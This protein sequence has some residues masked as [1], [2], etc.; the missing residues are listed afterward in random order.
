MKLTENTPKKKCFGTKAETLEMLQG[1]LAYSVILPLVRFTA[2]EWQKNPS[3]CLQ[4]IQSLQLHPTATVIIRSSALDEDSENSSAAGM[5]CSRLN[6]PV[7]DVKKLSRAIEEVIESFGADGDIAGHQVFAQP[8]LTD[9]LISGVVFTR[10][11]VTLAPYYVINYDDHSRLTDTVTSGKSND[12]KTLILYKNAEIRDERLKPLLRAIKEVEQILDCDCL[13]IE[14]SIDS[15]G[16]VYVFQARPI[17]TN[18]RSLPDASAIG[19]YLEKIHKKI[20]KLNRPHPYVHGERTFLGVMPD[21]NPAEMLGI[22]PRPLA[23]SLYKE[24]ITDKTW[25]HQRDNYG[26]K[27]L[28]SYPLLITLIGH[29]YVDVRVSFNSF[30]PKNLD[31]DLSAKLCNFYLAELERTPSSHDKIEFDII[32]SCFF[33]NLDDKLASLLTKGFTQDEARAIRESLRHLTNQII[34]PKYNC[35]E[36]DFAKINELVKRQSRVMGSELTR[37]EKIFWL[38]EDCRR[39]GTLPFAGLARGGFIAIQMLNSMVERGW[40]SPFEKE[41]FMA[42]LNTVTKQMARDE[43]QISKNDFLAKYGHLRPG[44]YD[45]LSKRYDEAFE[46]Y[47]GNSQRTNA[48]ICIEF[49]FQDSFIEKLNSFILNEGFECSAYELLHFIKSAIEGREHAKFVFTKS[50]SEILRLIG[51]LGERYSLNKEEVSFIDIRTLLGLYSTLDHRD[52]NTILKEEIIRNQHH[53]E[54][55]K[56]VRLPQLILKPDDVY[57]FELE[58]GTPNFITLGRV[59]AETVKDTRILN[60]SLKGKIVFIPSAD[61]GYDWIFTKGIS[62]LITMYGGANSHMAIRAAELKIPAV[63]GAG[64]KYYNAWLAGHALELDCENKS[65]RVIQ[66]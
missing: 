64:E 11:I 8:F 61:P 40:L 44:T 7:D 18:N 29:P 58:G 2:A 33:M 24:L 27:N 48:D 17:V 32:F 53:Y 13:D 6:I 26:Y 66:S 54:I 16:K 55:T 52:L 21:W 23:L 22:K 42:S 1:R 63:I 59:Q 60:S 4:A 62:G 12:V 46:Q 51:E 35:L 43:N 47:F 5:Y 31:D 15:K 20:T 39:Y 56:H 41:Q 10:D 28:R 19:H 37:L 57:E 25:A 36:N 3:R 38:V 34:S 49:E 9:C 50:V 14:F 45:I 30:I 65:V